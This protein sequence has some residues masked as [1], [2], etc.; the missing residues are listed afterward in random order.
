MPGTTGIDVIKQ[1][2]YLEM[3]ARRTPL[4]ALTADATPDTRAA[5][6]KAGVSVFL[7][8]PM[9]A[10][11]LL[12]ALAATADADAPAMV[13]TVRVARD[14]V[15]LDEAVLAE[16]ASLKLGS[17]FV[18]KFVDQCLR[19][20]ARSLATLEARAEA[21]DWDGVRDACH[22]AKGVAG[23]MGATQLAAAC[24]EGMRP[25]HADMVREWR[26][27]LASLHEHLAR[28]RMHAPEVLQRLQAL[29]DSDGRD[30]A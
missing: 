19:D 27:Y 10:S 28:V 8:K 5:A 16:L 18:G 4:I 13:E 22:A 20:A 21:G 9:V 15:V 25:M 30:K 29:A 24:S 17:D 3:G 12:D 23:N 26:P 11:E 14:A 1:A 7:T 6:Q 2:R